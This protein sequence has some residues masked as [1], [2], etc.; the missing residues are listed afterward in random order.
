MKPYKCSAGKW[1]IGIGRNLEDVGLNNAEQKVVLGTYA[2]SR[3][4]V[5]DAL[6][7]RG[8]TEEKAMYLLANDIEKCRAD[9]AGYGWYTTLDKIRQKVILDMRFN[10]GLAGLLTFKK[11]IAA[12]KDK[13]YARAADEMKDSKWYH[14]VGTRSVRLIKMMREGL[15][16]VV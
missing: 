3:I 10:L 12:L 8:I 6:L 1:T 5:I 2:L 16:Y 4:E 14:D 7:E 9:L 15:D 13:D 11:M